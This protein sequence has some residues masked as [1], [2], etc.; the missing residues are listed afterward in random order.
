MT[1]SGIASR[2]RLAGRRVYDKAVA[3]NDENI[4]R[5]LAAHA[6]V[7]SLL[8]L[9][10]DAGERTSVYAQAAETVDV[11]GVEMVDARAALA[12]ERGIS[13]VSADLG[14][15]LPFADQ[16]FDAVVSNQVIEHLFDTDMFVAEAY[17]VLKTG[18]IV[19]T[20]TENLASWHNVAALILGWQPFSLTNVSLTGSIGNPLGLAVGGDYREYAVGVPWQHR[21]V[22]AT[23]G[24][25][26]LHRGHGFTAV[27]SVGA[28]YF[29]LPSGLGRLNPAHAAFITVTGKR[30]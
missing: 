4:S 14:T 8:D 19:V 20:S 28:G 30:V 24:L 26:D 9:G 17:R 25:V 27:R 22:F 21:R 6:P 11:H 16:T 5:L 12:R 1:S 2:Y 10:C 13:V 15:P 29:P 23:R 7:G 18:G 3:Q